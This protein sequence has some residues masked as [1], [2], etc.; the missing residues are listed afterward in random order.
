MTIAVGDHLPQ[1]EF[2]SKTADGTQKLST[3]V[4]F[5]G[6]K[7][8]LFA[9]PGAFTPTC[10]RNHL[11]GYIANIDAIKAKGVDSVVCVTVNDVHVVDAW[12]EHT[13]AKGKITMLADD[14]GVFTKAV[15]MNKFLPRFRHGRTL[16]P[17]FHDRRQRRG[18]P[19]QPRGKT[20]RQRLRRGYDP[21]AVVIFS[22]PLRGRRKTLVNCTLQSLTLERRHALAGQFIGP[23][24][25]GVARVALH[26][27]PGD[28]MRR[29]GRIQPLPQL[30][31]L[32]RL[33]VGGFPAIALPA[34]NPLGD[35]VFDVGRVHMHLHLAGPLEG[36]KRR[37]GAHEFHAV[38]GGLGFAAGKFLARAV[39]GK[40]GAPAAGAGISRTRAIRM[41]DDLVGCHEAAATAR[42][43]RGNLNDTFSSRSTTFSTVTS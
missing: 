38:V 11:P 5:A 36:F 17:L 6:R 30:H 33:L 37:D 1:V 23:L 39:E 29:E 40:N 9:L 14:N 10:S 2:L 12:A 31:I 26:P 27:V 28:V 18:A 8:V 19:D 43:S 7:V 41:N 25:F 21:G 42:S 4:I 22:S 24:V 16:T 15:G 32:H 13:G 35:A 34:V 20:R 3:D